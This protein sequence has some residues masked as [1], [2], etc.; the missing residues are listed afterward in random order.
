MKQVVLSLLLFLF[1]QS[2]HSQLS[3]RYNIGSIG[4]LGDLERK[5]SGPYYIPGNQC[6]WIA[7]GIRTLSWPT[8]G[9]FL[10][11]CPSESELLYI[12]VYP[13]PA[14]SVI[15]VRAIYST[16]PIN[17]EH[18]VRIV[19]MNGEIR[20][21]IK[22]SNIGLKTGIKIPIYMLPRGYYVIVISASNIIKS[23]QFMKN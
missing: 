4:N 10:I 20:T 15:N 1:S 18:D 9:S 22:T 8:K 17:A 12:L 14:T 2:L 6:L 19:D 16:T 5:Y 11:T 13:N 7:N 23:I 21:I 3:M